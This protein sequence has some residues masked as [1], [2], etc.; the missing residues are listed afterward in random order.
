MYGRIIS[1]LKVQLEAHTNLVELIE[2]LLKWSGYVV[3]AGTVLWTA[4]FS[5]AA[6][7]DIDL[8]VWIEKET[9]VYPSDATWGKRLPLQLKEQA[10]SVDS[11][12]LYALRVSNYGRTMIGNPEAVWKLF[13]EAPFS[14]AVTVLDTA[15]SPNDLVAAAQPGEQ[16]NSL[17]IE[18]GALQPRASV[19]LTVMLVNT[20]ENKYPRFV[21]KPSLS[22][23][24]HRLVLGSPAVLMFETI[25]WHVV[26]SLFVVLLVLLGPSSY[27]EARAKHR[28]GWPL[29]VSLFWRVVGVAAL[30][31]VGGLVPGKGIAHVM[32]WFL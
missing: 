10:I 7:N 2:R 26:G 6:K 32:V 21:V 14:A 20:D 27:V 18:V 11:A 9:S 24:P 23:L 16:P 19:L 17:L 15:K 30:A 5:L 4:L 31:C 29:V 13:I 12:R 25:A 8:V 22:G 3:V 1:K 28:G